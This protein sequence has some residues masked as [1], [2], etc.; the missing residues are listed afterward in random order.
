MRSARN[1]WKWFIKQRTKSESSHGTKALLLILMRCTHSWLGLRITGDPV[2]WHKT[3]LEATQRF[4]MVENDFWFM[5]DQV[6]TL[7]FFLFQALHAEEFKKY[8]VRNS[9]NVYTERLRP[10]VQTITLLCT[11]FHKKGIPFIYLLLTNGTP[12]TYRVCDFASLL[13]AVNALSFQ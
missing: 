12:F 10:E 7:I 1:V 6:C 8:Q 3:S 4:S 2:V 5:A 11:I 13:T 9:T